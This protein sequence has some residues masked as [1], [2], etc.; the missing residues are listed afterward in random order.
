MQTNTHSPL[1]MPALRARAHFNIRA[2]ADAVVGASRVT[3]SARAMADWVRAAQTVRR[4]EYLRHLCPGVRITAPHTEGGSEGSV[5]TIVDR[6]FGEAP[7]KLETLPVAFTFA[8][9][10]C[11][12]PIKRQLAENPTNAQ[13]A[14][15]PTTVGRRPSV[16]A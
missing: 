13:D 8:A 3:S 2:R 15:C 12:L 7:G 16:A 11:S 9:K 14:N 6:A 5:R 4:F 1:G 10:S